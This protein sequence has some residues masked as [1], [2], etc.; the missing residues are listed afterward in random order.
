MAFVQAKRRWY[1]EPNVVV[2]LQQNA[3]DV[4]WLL[5]WHH[6]FHS[7]HKAPWHVLCI[8]FYVFTLGCFL[9]WLVLGLIM[10]NH[11]NRY[12]WYYMVSVFRDLLI[13]PL[14]DQEARLWQ[15]GFMEGLLSKGCQ[16]C[17]QTVRLCMLCGGKAAW[18][19]LRLPGWCVLVMVLIWFN[20]VFFP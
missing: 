9:T 20:F 18:S 4:T 19:V 8:Y 1:P 2:T 6:W 11:K 5:L 7:P 17:A 12:K 3:V 15:R 13:P 14:Q 16:T 10:T